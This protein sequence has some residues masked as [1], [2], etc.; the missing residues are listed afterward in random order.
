[1]FERSLQNYGLRYPK[2]YGDG[3]SN[4]FN[5]VENVYEGVKVAKL[6]C[7]GHCQKHVGNRLRKLK[8]RVKGLGGQVKQKE[9]GKVIKT[10][11]KASRRLTDALID[12]LQKYFGI[13]LWSSAETVPGSKKALLASLFHVMSS[14]GNNFH[15]YCPVG[16]NINVIL[17]TNINVILSTKSTYRSLVLVYLLM[18][19]RK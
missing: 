1:M 5:A 10:K 16:T 17:S 15:S 18:S 2:F 14:E 11:V 3:D 7:I 4:G 8:K 12:K 13:A 19:S 9:G 6:K